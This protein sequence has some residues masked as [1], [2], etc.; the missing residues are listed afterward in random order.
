MAQNT[1][2]LDL[3]YDPDIFIAMMA[4]LREKM[5]D[6][7]PYISKYAGNVYLFRTME[8]KRS[9][10]SLV[11]I[12]FEQAMQLVFFSWRE[13]PEKTM[14]INMLSGLGTHNVLIGSKGNTL[15][16]TF[17]AKDSNGATTDE[18]AT[19]NYT[20]TCNGVKQVLQEQYNAGETA[21]LN[22]DNYLQEGTNTITIQVRGNESK[23]MATATVVYILSELS[24][25]SNFNVARAYGNGDNMAFNVVA[26]GLSD[27]GTIYVEYYIDGEHKGDLSVSPDEIGLEKRLSID[28]ALLPTAPGKHTL[29]LRTRATIGVQERYSR[30]WY[31]EW[32]RVGQADQYVTVKCMLTDSN[33]LVGLPGVNAMLKLF[34][35]RYIPQTIE[36]G[37]YSSNAGDRAEVVWKMESFNG[38]DVVVGSADI[39]TNTAGSDG[40]EYKMVFMPTET[41]RFVL[42]AYINGVNKVAYD[43]EVSPNSSGLEEA[44]VT[45]LLFR[46][47]AMGRSN[48]EPADQRA[49]WEYK[50]VKATF[51]GVLWNGVSGWVNNALQLAEGA[52]CTIPVAP[53]AQMASSDNGC[54][55][56]IDFEV[57]N[58]SDDN[59]VVIRCG[60]SIEVTGSK[61]L[62]MAPISRQSINDRFTA[63]RRLTL[64]FV[65][66]PKNSR[67]QPL[68]MEIINKGI[69]SRCMGYSS[70]ENFLSAANIVLGGTTRCGIRIYSVRAYTIALTNKQELNN[71]IVSADD[72]ATMVRNNDIYA[73]TAVDVEKI[74][75]RIP[76][77]WVTGRGGADRLQSIWDSQAKVQIHVDAEWTNP[78]DG[79]AT[80]WRCTDMRLRSHGQSTLRNPMK[81]LKMWIKTESG[82][83]VH[84]TQFF[85]RDDADPMSDPRW[86]MRAGA[87]PQTKFVAQCY[88]IDSSNCKSPSLLNIIDEVMR[89]SGIYTEP[90]KYAYA[91][92]SRG[93]NYSE[94]MTRIHGV[95]PSG[96]G[97]PF[98][99]NIRYTPDSIPCVIISRDDENS[100]WQYTGIFVLMDDKKSDYLYGERSIYDCPN[101]PYCFDHDKDEWNVLWDNSNVTRFEYLSNTHPLSIDAPRGVQDF[102]RPP[103]MFTPD[104]DE[105]EVETTPGGGE[106]SGAVSSDATYDFEQALELIYPDIDDLRGKNKWPLNYANVGDLTNDSA[107]ANRLYILKKWISECRAA[108]EAGDGYAK[109]RREAA[110]HL[111]LEQ[112][113]CYYCVAMPNGTFDNIVR[114]LQLTTFHKGAAGYHIWLP[115]WWDIDIQD[116]TI[117]TGQLA[118]DPPVDRQTETAQYGVAFRGQESWLWDAFEA[119]PEFIAGCRDRMN[120]LNK[121]GYTYDRIIAKQDE[122]C[123]TWP[124]AM[125]NE[126]QN[127]KYKQM[128]LSNPASN[129]RYLFYLLGDGRVF[130]RWWLK[131]N[132]DY[133]MSLLAA[134]D[135]VKNGIV[136]RWNGNSFS[137]TVTF[138]E[139]SFFMWAW[140]DESSKGSSLVVQENGRYSTPVNRGDTKTIYILTTSNSQYATIYSGSSIL[141]MDCSDNA[142][143]LLNGDFTHFQDPILGTNLEVLNVGLSDEKLLAGKRNGANGIFAGWGALTKIKKL[144]IQGHYAGFSPEGG[145]GESLDLSASTQLTHIYAKGSGYSRIDFAESLH[146]EVAELPSTLSTISMRGVAFA[147]LSF[148]EPD[149]LQQRSYPSTLRVATFNGMGGDEC[150]RRLIHDWLADNEDDLS[151]LSLNISALNWDYCS[152]EEIVRMGR[153]PAAQ[154]NYQGMVRI[155]NVGGEDRL[156]TP[157]E[158]NLLVELFNDDEKGINVFSPNSV[159]RIDCSEGFILTGPTSLWAGEYGTIVAA[160]FPI[161]EGGWAYHYEVTHINGNTIPSNYRPN[162]QGI[163]TINNFV[164][165]CNTGLIETTEAYFADCEFT[166]LAVATDGRGGVRQNSMT[167]M[168][169]K[170]IYPQTLRIGGTLLIDTTGEYPYTIQYDDA[171]ASATGNSR[172]NLRS[173]DSFEWQLTGGTQSI[174]LRNPKVDQATLYVS[175]FSED[176]EL[177][178]GYQAYY[179]DAPWQYN[180]G[181]VAPT[182]TIQLIVD[183]ISIIFSQ[184]AD[185]DLYNIFDHWLREVIGQRDPQASVGRVIYRREVLLFDDGLPT[186]L[187]GNKNLTTF[188]Q[189][190]HFKNLRHANLSDSA[191]EDIVDVTT[192]QRLESID[193]RGTCAGIKF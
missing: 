23:L 58:V 184:I 162:A 138:A 29:Q 147:S 16:F 120:Q 106:S 9:F 94:D 96:R 167:V 135:A 188:P 127:V 85:N 124:E 126:S 19:V 146:L 134:G 48:T 6:F 47:F 122:Y 132:W 88:Y 8:A 109:F 50:D 116:G 133:W 148:F 163:Q 72:I 84:N 98:P 130:R 2:P 178:L 187:V 90:M 175:N 71:V 140:G 64:A 107:H 92:D 18:P 125:Y 137:G 78:L 83:T 173:D 59:A 26:K 87:M 76:C 31:Y 164:L 169:R 53:F 14:S 183:A 67:T 37:F 45:D 141:E 86:S 36:Y 182:I 70:S 121:A 33:V 180:T 105:Q 172:G 46:G 55:I 12:N 56:E 11:E 115:L 151:R 131:K 5:L 165:N 149:T 136:F 52:S 39:G 186:D 152:F 129:A 144:Y 34:C 15:E 160:V 100:P 181:K 22:I 119:W 74:R 35:E 113:Q 159:F 114:N 27:T 190:M 150:V 143:M 68:L 61:A 79:G 66:H 17:T 104:D 40:T 38:D 158:M 170:R 43:V 30:V 3:N 73:G 20:F 32:V 69:T 117:N 128:Y 177:T 89:G 101:D 192:L 118:F 63:N 189:L 155:T 93:R 57:F 142:E 49:L 4:F 123:D 166:I 95:D 145:I 28:S 77:L 161:S 75:N 156:L 179:K 99:Y 24:V 42:R 185:Y 80:N 153:I 193:L 176:M 157:D 25:E 41:G 102:F 112:W 110:D 7:T 174:V 108:Q 54:T 111:D 82:Q 51:D 65:V 60:E 168:L 91:R 62:L 10:D 171:Y 191:L 21:V 97:W 44:S 154:R 139:S 13:A 1:A 103:Q 81:S